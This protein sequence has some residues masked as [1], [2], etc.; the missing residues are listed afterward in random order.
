MR[1][2]AA[3]RRHSS[4][5]GAARTTLRPVPA[6]GWRARYSCLGVAGQAQAMQHRLCHV[7][8]DHPLG[9]AQLLADLRIA[10]SGQPCQQEG[11]PRSLGQAGQ[12]VGDGMQQLQCLRA[13][14]RRRVH[15]LRLRG[16]RGQIGTLQ[17]GALPVVDQQRVRDGAEVGTRQ[18]QLGRID[19]T[20][21]QAQEGVL[22]QV[23]SAIGVVG[24]AA[25][26]AQQ[27]TMVF[28]VEPRQRSAGGGGHG[29]R[30]R[31]LM[32]MIPIIG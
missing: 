21:E 10:E 4:P 17:V 2:S 32:R 6:P 31:S 26:P 14:L 30:H 24:A 9:H 5:A 3:G 29:H 1:A 13:F 23:G 19:A 25:Q 28:A 11:A 16:Q 27:P 8:L 7:L 22:G 18:A 12:H 15:R 20:A